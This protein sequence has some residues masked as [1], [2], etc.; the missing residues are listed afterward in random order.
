M[1]STMLAAEGI[2]VA[3]EAACGFVAAMTVTDGDRRIG[4]LHRAPWAG[5]DEAMPPDA[6]A[7]LRG[8]KGDF[9]CAPFAARSADGSDFHGWPANGHWTSVPGGSAGCR[10]W[11]LDHA[12]EGAT[13]V[14]ELSVADGQPFLYQR[15][16]FLGG[17]GDLPVANHAMITLPEGGHLRFS[18]KRWFE[19]PATPLE[20][21]PARGRSRL[22]PATRA[23]DPQAF[24]AAGGGTLDLTRYPWAGRDEDF[25]A[26]IEAEGSPLGWTA[27]SRTGR[28]DLFLSLRDPR[29]L[30]MTMLWHSNGGRDYPPWNGRHIACLGVEEGAALHVLGQ[31]ARETPDPL[32]A[33]GMAA[34]LTLDPE[35]TAELRHVLGMIAWPSG[36]PVASVVLSGDVLA[37]TGEGG[38]RRDLPIR[39]RFLFP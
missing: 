34:C 1:D 14:K 6:A 11:V 33:G 5:T 4:M 13:L 8:L 22:R 2:E 25:V 23:T 36:E 12:V 10:R 30:P 39:G 19:T 21:D 31:S 20:T 28:G 29:A 17:R 15:H 18:P 38:A 27:V 35:G 9:F 24:P 16:V 26:A 37:V 3:F 32:T 7:H